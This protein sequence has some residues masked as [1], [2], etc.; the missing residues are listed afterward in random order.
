MSL[1]MIA[2]TSDLKPVAARSLLCFRRKVNGFLSNL[3]RF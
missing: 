2:Q 1:R 3:G